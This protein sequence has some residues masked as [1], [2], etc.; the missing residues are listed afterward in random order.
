MLPP[1]GECE[2]W[3]MGGVVRGFERGYVILV[4]AQTAIPTIQTMI[5]R[6][7]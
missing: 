2:V 5:V 3:I 4:Q 7:V 6:C 1:R